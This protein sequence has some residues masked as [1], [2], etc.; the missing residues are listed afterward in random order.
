M[1]ELSGSVGVQDQVPSTCTVVVQIT[2]SLS[3]AS[4]V[5]PNVLDSPVIA[6]VRVTAGNDETI[7]RFRDIVI[8][9]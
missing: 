4:I 8:G 6:G 5:S 2:T 7:R 3:T 9:Q 1:P